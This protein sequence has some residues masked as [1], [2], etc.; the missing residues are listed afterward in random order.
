MIKNRKIYL[1]ILTVFL[2]IAEII[3]VKSFYT[4]EIL[5]VLS[6]FYMK[7]Q[8]SYFWDYV[9]IFSERK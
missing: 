7:G 5:E 6:G 3:I 4:V 8:F 2:L 1:F 9:I